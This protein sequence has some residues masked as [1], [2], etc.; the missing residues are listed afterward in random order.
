MN[1]EYTPWGI[2]GK[3]APGQV[4]AERVRNRDCIQK[5][6]VMHKGTVMEMTTKQGAER[7]TAL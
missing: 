4:A 7:P 1:R 5:G 2:L 3:G 6:T